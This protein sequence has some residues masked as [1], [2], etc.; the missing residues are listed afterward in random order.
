MGG[1]PPTARGP[2]HV[3]LITAKLADRP[4]GE[5]VNKA[6]DWSITKSAY[7]SVSHMCNLMAN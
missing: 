4:S 2:E 7:V 6:F 5:D 3:I 1:T